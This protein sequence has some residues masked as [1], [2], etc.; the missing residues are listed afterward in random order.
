MLE[1]TPKRKKRKGGKCVCV[2]VWGGGGGGDVYIFA[3]LLKIAMPLPPQTK[4]LD[5]TLPGQFRRLVK[6]VSHRNVKAFSI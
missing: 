1:G 4:V 2:C 6:C 3:T 5:E